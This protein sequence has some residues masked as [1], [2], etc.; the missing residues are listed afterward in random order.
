MAGVT[1]QGSSGA[2]LQGGSGT[3]A[4]KIQG[5]APT[6]QSANNA[7]MVLQPATGIPLNGGQVLGASTVSATQPTY[8]PAAAAAA[9]D[10]AAKTAQIN[11]LKGSI[12]GLVK[13]IH[14]VYDAIYGSATNQATDKVGQINKNFGDQEDQLSKTFNSNVSSDDNNFAGRGAGDSS[15][16]LDSRQNL[17]DTFNSGQNSLENEKQGDISDVGSAL[18]STQGGIAADST[19][20][21]QILSRVNQSTDPSELQTIM[22]TIQD[23]L[24]TLNGGQSAY[25]TTA[26]NI[27]AAP[28]ASNNLSSLQSSLN[29]IVTG[30]APTAL[31]LSVGTKLIQTAGLSDADKQ[32]A[33]Q[34]LQTAL[35]GDGTTDPTKTT[36]GQ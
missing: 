3:G 35:A 7:S 21:D 20:V 18:A 8:D 27:A 24:N 9:A 11:Q 31:K 1:I 14:S 19:S 26:Q 29:N 36:T 32:T 17:A 30:S 4:I 33:I 13:N 2:A 22:G 16:H 28:T 12:A 23:K 25:N 6:L 34:Q 15:Y 5:S 10:A